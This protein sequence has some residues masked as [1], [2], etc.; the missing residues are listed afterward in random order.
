MVTHHFQL[1]FVRVYTSAEFTL[2]PYMFSAKSIEIKPMPW[3]QRH[4][5][6]PLALI[7]ISIPPPLAGIEKSRDSGCDGAEG[8][9]GG[10][11]A[12]V[13]CRLPD[14]GLWERTDPPAVSAAVPANGPAAARWKPGP[15]AAGDQSLSAQRNAGVWFRNTIFFLQT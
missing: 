1:H 5:L 7:S 2:L 3:P 9:G 4:Y 8:P 10:S 14:P 6:S 15:Y 13:L 12:A 11:P